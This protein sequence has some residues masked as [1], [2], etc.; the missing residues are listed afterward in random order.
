MRKRKAPR[1][2]HRDRRPA[3][4]D[5]TNEPARIARRTGYR[6]DSERHRQARAK[7]PAARRAEIAHMGAAARRGK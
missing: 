1:R 6:H 5:R 3:T 2:Q 7:V 4:R